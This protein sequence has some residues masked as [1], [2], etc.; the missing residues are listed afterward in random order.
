MI[1]LPGKRYWSHASDSFEVWG[2]RNIL[3]ELLK[4]SG[5]PYPSTKSSP[6]YRK[7]LEIPFCLE[8]TGQP[9]VVLKPKWVDAPVF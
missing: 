4:G 2:G 5:N 8:G 6:I 9:F 7:D 1:S 3:L